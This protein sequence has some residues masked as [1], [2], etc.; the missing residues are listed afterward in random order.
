[1]QSA[2]RATH[3]SA[4]PDPWQ[5]VHCNPA[6]HPSSRSPLRF[7]SSPRR[8]CE[9]GVP[10]LAYPRLDNEHGLLTSAWQ[11]LNLYAESMGEESDNSRVRSGAV[12]VV[13][14][15]SA[16]PNPSTALVL[17]LLSRT[18]P[19]RNFGKKSQ[20]VSNIRLLLAPVRRTTRFWFDRDKQRPKKK[21]E[22][23]YI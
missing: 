4:A 18:R 7:I 22:K 9:A 19:K 13:L 10:K 1:M 16:Q 17:L 5:P 6:L 23:R 2:A 20:R 12:A 21:T 14:T 11:G 8:N 15:P 3:K